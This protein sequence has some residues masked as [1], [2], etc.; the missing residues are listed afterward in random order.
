M[1]MQTI[2]RRNGFRGVRG[3][4]AAA[5]L[6]A[7]AA[8]AAEF[9]SDWQ[10]TR[11]WTGPACW[12]NPLQDWRVEDGDLVGDAA[13][14][15]T[16]HCLTHDTG[17][18]NAAFRLDVTVRLD[19]AKPPSM[20]D[21]VWGGFALGLR[22][23]I[24]DARHALIYSDTRVDAGLRADGRV[25][26]GDA[27]GEGSVDAAKPSRLA[28]CAE[29]VGGD[30]RL[31]VTATQDHRSS[32]ATA[33]VP[34]ALLRGNLALAAESP[35]RRPTEG[36]RPP[37]RWRFHD[38]RASGPRVD[39]HP[40]RAFGPVLWTQYTISRGV[41]K[42]S[43]QFPPLG[44]ADA[45]EATLQVRRGDVWTDAA[46]ASIDPMA[47]TAVFRI[48]PWDGADDVPCRVTYPWR[49]RT[50]EWAGTIRREPIERD[51][52][53]VAA[54]SCDIGTAFPQPRMVRNLAIQNPDLL[55]FLGDQIYESYGGFGMT[56]APTDVAMLDYLRKFYQ[57][58]WTWR[59]LL[60]DRP[61]VIIPDDHDVFQGNLWGHGGR[62]LPGT[63]EKDFAAGGYAMP[64]DWVNAVHRTQTGHLPDPPDPA[65]MDQGISVYFTDLLYG[66][67]SFAILEDRAFKTGP[68]SVL[69][70]RPADAAA[71]DVPADLL[72]TRQERF[73]RGWAAD[74]RSTDLKVA[75][76]QTIFCKV[77]THAGQ[78][79]KP[80]RFDTDCGGWPP[81]GRRRALEEIRRGFAF[82]IH[83]DQHSGALVHHGLDDWEDA[84]V[85][86]LVMGTANGFPRAWWPDAPGENHIAGRAPW[87]GRYRDIYGNRMTVLAAGN[88]EKGSNTLK[89]FDP[90]EIAHLK[91]SG[92]GIVRLDKAQ[93]TATFELWRH[94]FDAAAPK[95]GDQFPD[96]PQTYR[97][98][99]NYARRAAAW[100]P[101]LDVSGVTNPVVQVVRE[102]T[103]EVVY[104]LRIRGTAFRPRVFAEGTY[105]IRV[106]EPGTERDKAVRGLRAEPEHETARLSVQL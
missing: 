27:A 22:G 105:T 38:W 80:G 83:G 106:G 101:A 67:V 19:S 74:W 12:A 52:L 33:L 31:T 10:G 40:E 60:K 50:S 36:D 43:A 23:A 92:H 45:K 11:D 4:A 6:A 91:G 86:F 15:R 39:A 71:Y 54:F 77:T 55:C 7:S 18:T 32:T 49:G 42:L 75:L 89:D 102:D 79:L 16:V 57:F 70:G 3:R 44:P 90:Q 14:N 5:W 87:T 8:G 35:R 78:D 21:K 46:R 1:T 59:D 104:T 9:A 96:F 2:H 66:R 81:A 68:R 48:A 64:P 30:T 20:P 95:P 25:F 17:G 93:G 63:G 94:D 98:E 13:R 37:I 53:V 72:G 97:L 82:S 34:A 28:L 73:L 103:G 88:P 85:A 65:P 100:L 24:D 41:L 29:S 56:R 84:N 58:G 76:S 62:A 26:V 47:R 99:D 61:S 69:K 51:N